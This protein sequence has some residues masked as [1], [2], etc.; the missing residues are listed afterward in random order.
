V[1]TQF[2]KLVIPAEYR[3]RL[4]YKY[5]TP[6]ARALCSRLDPKTRDDY[7][8]V[9]AAVMKECGLTAKSFLAKFNSLRKANND[10]FILFASKLDGLLRQYLEA[11]KVKKFE[12]LVIASF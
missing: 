10:T 6:R 1:E 2:E 9:K 12:S 5:L 11:R 4:I 3:A 8:A 7:E